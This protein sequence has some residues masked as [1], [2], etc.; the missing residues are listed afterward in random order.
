[1]ILTPEAEAL[2][3]MQ[4]SGLV[5]DMREAASL[6]TNFAAALTGYSALATR[7]DQLAALDDLL[8][9]WSE[10]SG[11]PTMIDRALAA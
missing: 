5:R 6:D 7:E 4:G 9:K 1:M 3:T 2:P 8:L 11:M 10:T